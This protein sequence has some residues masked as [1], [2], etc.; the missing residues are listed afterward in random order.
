MRIFITGTDTNVGK[1][2][3]SAWLCL[4]FG[5]S[6]WKPIQSGSS[7]SLDSDIIKSI[8]IF[9]YTEAYTL[10]AAASP[11]LAARSENIKINLDNILENIPDC[12]RLLIEGAGGV[13][14]PLNENDLIIDLITKLK[15][16]VIVVSR[17]TIGTIN[18]TCLTIN[19]LRARKIPILGVIMNGEPN[20][21][22][23]MAI[24]KY[25]K[26][27]VLH[28]LPFLNL[29][30]RESLIESKPSHKLMRVAN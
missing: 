1:T 2:L 16:Q 13:M 18:H 27:R 4:H 6:Y 26:T 28:E 8:G 15:A 29:I 20:L 12:N 7:E 3:V 10:K 11:H 22:N 19:A 14:V 5:F 23:R 21:E 25:S 24:E 9:T 17:T 30:C